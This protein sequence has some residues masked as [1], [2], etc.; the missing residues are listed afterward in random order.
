MCQEAH[1]EWKTVDLF[2]CSVGA[3]VAA[4]QALAT[5]IY[6]LDISRLDYCNIHYVGLPLKTLEIS[7][8]LH[9]VGILLLLGI[10]WYE[11]IKGLNYNAT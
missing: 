6:A 5:T 4:R 3:P 11:H 9:N 1:A 10:G 7:A 2:L 8:C